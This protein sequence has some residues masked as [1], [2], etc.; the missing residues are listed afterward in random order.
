MAKRKYSDELKA[1]VVKECREIGN[2]ALVAR[3][4]D[5]SKNTVYSWVNK[6]KKNGSVKSLPKNKDKQFK[7]IKKRLNKLGTEN[8]Q[9]KKLL[10]EKEL[11]LAILRDLRDQ[12]NPQ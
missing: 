7:E 10:A 9:L 2:I 11:E 8:D 1:Q 6:A 4:H 5:I 3:R 12:S